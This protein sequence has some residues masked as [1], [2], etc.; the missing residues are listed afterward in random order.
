[1]GFKPTASGIKAC[2]ADQPMFVGTPFTKVPIPL[3]YLYVGM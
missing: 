1:M 2:H 3:R